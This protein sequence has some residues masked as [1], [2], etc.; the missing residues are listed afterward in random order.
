MVQALAKHVNE[1]AF[2]WGLGLGRFFIHRRLIWLMVAATLTIIG[3]GLPRLAGDRAAGPAGED[4]TPEEM[5][6]LD[7]PLYQHHGDLGRTAEST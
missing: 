2:W 3:F 4:A 7:K 6:M 1:P 5:A